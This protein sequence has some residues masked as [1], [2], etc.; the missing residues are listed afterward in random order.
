MP[1][2]KR[3]SKGGGANADL[4]TIIIRCL[5][6]AIIGTVTFFAILV[7][8]SFIALKADLSDSLY[9]YLV[10]ADGA[11]SG[12]VCGFATVRP[13]RKNGIIFGAVSALPMFIIT[14]LTAF[15]TSNSGLGAIGWIL[16]GVMIIFSAIGGIL[17]V[18]K[19]K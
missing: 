2:N 7:L 6:G 12:F 15:L 4:R 3:K 19:R 13:I 1:E 9:K 8:M 11:V 10:L 16:A 5:T 18:N 14:A 17:A